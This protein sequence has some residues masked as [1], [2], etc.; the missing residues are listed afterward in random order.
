MICRKT[1]Y[2]IIILLVAFNAEAS[3][4][5]NETDQ[6]GNYLSLKRMYQKW[7]NGCFGSR[8]L[9][10]NRLYRLLTDMI[11]TE[12]QT[13]RDYNLSLPELFEKK[14]YSSDLYNNSWLHIHGEADDLTV[15]KFSGM[16]AVS[17]KQLER[18]RDLFFLSGRIK[19]FRIADNGSPGSVHL[20]LESVHITDSM[21]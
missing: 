17:I 15:K 8:T 5:S 2:M 11:G 14:Y 19:Y 10:R 1:G 4:K 18:N 20:F 21:E 6:R 12:I 13:G 7:E 3:L 9:Y 16:D